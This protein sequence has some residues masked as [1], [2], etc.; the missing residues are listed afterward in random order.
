MEGDVKQLKSIPFDYRE[1]HQDLFT[2]EAMRTMID[3]AISNGQTTSNNNVP[4][5]N[6]QSEVTSETLKLQNKSKKLKHF[7]FYIMFCNYFLNISTC[8]LR[9][10]GEKCFTPL[11]NNP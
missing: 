2:K 11:R 3:K 10:F 7:D 8:F 9:F 5:N 4:V 6:A 1:Q